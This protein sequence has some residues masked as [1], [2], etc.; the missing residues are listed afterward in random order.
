[1]YCIP[2]LEVQAYVVEKMKGQMP[3]IKSLSQEMAQNTG[4][5]SPLPEVVTD[6]TY[7]QK[8]WDSLI[9]PNQTV[10]LAQPLGGIVENSDLWAHPWTLILMQRTGNLNFQ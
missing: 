6:T 10:G 7:M 3:S 9:L 5:L 8:L 1:M 4:V 2:V